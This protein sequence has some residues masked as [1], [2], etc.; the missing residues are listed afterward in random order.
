MLGS[1]A[2]AYV[3]PSSSCNTVLIFGIEKG[4]LTSLLFTSQKLLKSIQ[5]CSSLVE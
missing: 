1:R 2:V 4:F 3:N 5:S